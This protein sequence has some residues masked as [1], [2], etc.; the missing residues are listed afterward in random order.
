[1]HYCGL[2]IS[3]VSHST[4]SLPNTTWKSGIHGADAA[5]SHARLTLAFPE[6]GHLSSQLSLMTVTTEGSMNDDIFQNHLFPLDSHS[7]YSCL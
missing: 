1:M 2:M 7:L 5:L 4:H 6:I 3:N